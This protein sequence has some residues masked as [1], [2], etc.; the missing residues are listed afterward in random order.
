MALTNYWWLL[1]W[2]FTG[3]LLI[4]IYTPKK[5][6]IVCGKLENRWTTLSAMLLVLPYIIWA[7]FRSDR[8]GDTA[9]Y[10]QMF[11]NAP[12][13]LSQLGVYMDEASK[14]KGFY[15]LVV[16]I[17]SII[18]N[19]DVLFFLIIATFQLA[20]IVYIFKK[21]SCD[22]WLS[23]FIFVAVTDYMSWMHNGIRQFIAVTIVFVSNE[24][25]IR[26]QY[27]KV[28]LLILLASTFHASALLMVP[29]LFIIQGKA[30]NKRSIMALGLAL[31]AILMVDRFTD[32][33]DIM[34]AETQYSN[35]VSDWKTW[36]D[37][38]TNPLRVLVYAVPTILSVVGLK[39]I[40]EEDNPMINLSVNTSICATAIYII[41]SFTSGIFIGRLPAYFLYLGMG[42]LLPWEI[43]HIFTKES[44][45]FVRIIA[46]LLYS[47]FFYYQMHFAWGLL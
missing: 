4:A 29:S 36:E 7:G 8:F 5:R 27:V 10:R 9:G 17:K 12:S 46:V 20:C 35:M 28:I 24:F 23:I 30:W 31:L 34:L 16:V 14:D 47:L 19:S 22:F 42:V 44:Q 25:L 21:Y 26:K 41:S 1:I 38:G 15:A 3:G 32:F 43:E 13:N 18:G 45:I 33:L 6:K 2:M 40:R 39:W 11:R 37:D